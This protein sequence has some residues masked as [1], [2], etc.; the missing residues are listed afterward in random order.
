[1]NSVMVASSY[2]K[3]AGQRHQHQQYHFDLIGMP[4]SNIFNVVNYSGRYL[5]LKFEKSPIGCH[6]SEKSQIVSVVTHII[7]NFSNPLSKQYIID[8]LVQCVYKHC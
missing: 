3:E 4:K 5:N 2:H 6:D 7:L 8:V 1:M